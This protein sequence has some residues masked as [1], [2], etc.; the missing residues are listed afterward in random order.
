VRSFN[1]SGYVK[2]FVHVTEHL[3]ASMMALEAVSVE[4]GCSSIMLTTPYD[5]VDVS[6]LRLC[7]VFRAEAGLAGACVCAGPLAWF[8]R[9]RFL[10]PER[11]K[12]SGSRN[13]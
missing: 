6:R 1:G 9:G 5:H 4:A 13:R 3:S 7:P 11:L 10:S 8:R 12:S 2:L